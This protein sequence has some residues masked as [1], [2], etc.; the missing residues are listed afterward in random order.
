MNWLVLLEPILG[1]LISAGPSIARAIRN[2]DKELTARRI[3]EATDRAIVVSIAKERARKRREE[4][5]ASK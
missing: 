3:R 4:R 1:A 5:K 2:G